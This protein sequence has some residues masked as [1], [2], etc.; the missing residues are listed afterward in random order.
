MR[1]PEGLD[2]NA[3]IRRLYEGYRTVVAGSRTS[4]SGRL[5][6]IGTMGWVSESDILT[7]LHYIERALTDLGRAPREGAGV[8]AAAALLAQPPTERRAAA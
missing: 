2:G 4:L 5:I 7:D 8:A 6:R 1:M 3:M